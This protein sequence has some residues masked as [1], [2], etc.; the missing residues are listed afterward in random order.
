MTGPREKCAFRT[1]AR[2][3]ACLVDDTTVTA[4][5]AAVTA[6]ELKQRQFVFFA[7]FLATAFFVA[8]FFLAI[9]ATL[10]Q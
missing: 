10:R 8:G 9:P 7:A 2:R 1:R 6:F 4:D 5:Q 3:L